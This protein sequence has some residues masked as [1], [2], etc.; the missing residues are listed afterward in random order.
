MRI[1]VKLLVLLAWGAICGFADTPM[2]SMRGK[3]VLRAAKSPYIQESNLVLGALDTLVV[4]PGV[5]VRMK[6]YV[7]LYLRG[8]VEIRGTKAKPVRFLSA[9]SQD[10][11][12]GIHFATGERPFLVEHLVVE[13]AF[14]NSV[15]SSQGAFINSRFV[16]NYYGLWVESSPL[17]VISS[18]EFTRNRFALSIGSGAVKIEKCKLHGNVYGLNL[19]KGSRIEG[20]LSQSKDNAEADVR[21]EA[22]ELSGKK[23][24]LARHLWRKIESGF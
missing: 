15:S 21:D 8:H 24:R 18:S 3:V 20:D 19:E 13:N 9:D 7:R 12:V 17:L 22:A 6:G 23:N 4:E 10:T 11:W 5:T 16:N 14:R 1:G 2:P